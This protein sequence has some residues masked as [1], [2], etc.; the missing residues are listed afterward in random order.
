M[1]SVLCLELVLL[2]ALPFSRQPAPMESNNYRK[3]LQWKTLG[4]RFIRKELK[5]KKM[6]KTVCQM[7]WD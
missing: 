1:F 3:P 6:E 7:L 4:K 2:K 5:K